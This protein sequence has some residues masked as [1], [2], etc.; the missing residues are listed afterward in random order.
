MGIRFRVSKFLRLMPLGLGLAAL[1]GAP[2]SAQAAATSGLRGSELGLALLSAAERSQSFLGNYAVPVL[3]VLA[4]LLVLFWLGFTGPLLVS[5]HID[6]PGTKKE[7]ELA[8]PDSKFVRVHG[9]DLHYK[10][11]GQG[12]RVFVLFN[13]FATSL[14]S[15]R[16]V[17]Q[18]L[19]K[20]GRV[21]AFDR[22]GM[23]LSAHPVRGDWDRAGKSPYAPSV[24]PEFAIGLMDQLGIKKAILMGHSAGGSVVLRTALKYPQR[25]A[26]IVVAGAD[27]IST[28]IMPQGGLHR[29]WDT[30]R[31]HHLGAWTFNALFGFANA[32]M[33][34]KLGYHDASR[35]SREELAALEKYYH[36]HN[37]GVA[38][39]EYA[40]ANEKN[41]LPATVQNIRLPALLI[42]GDDDRV[43]PTRDQ[44]K[45]S[46]RIA[47][48]Q[49]RIIKDCGHLPQEEQ[50]EAFVSAVRQFV[51]QLPPAEHPTDRRA[52]S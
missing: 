28:G 9:Y 41:T 6:D 31:M 18:P 32:G 47:G 3:A 35:C 29:L 16:K 50:P 24:A 5:E 2:A 48:S 20:L 25:V 36:V 46:E 38:L 45:L 4:V 30:L 40:A 11:L 49:L 19:A 44:V 17:M 51:E 14:M 13:G 1:G 10:E 39:W 23:G 42:A 43:V 34:I 27:W 26:A 21:I 37:V 12:E 15:W 7:R 8:D 52:S 33:M 22:L